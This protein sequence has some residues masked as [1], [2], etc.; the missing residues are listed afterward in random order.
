MLNYSNFIL[1][2]VEE[3][4]LESIDN[5]LFVLSGQL[6]DILNDVVDSNKDYSRIAKVFLDLD[7]TYHDKLAMSYFD[8]GSDNQSITYLNPVKVNKIRKEKGWT[9]S[10]AIK[11]LMSKNSIRIGKLAN[12]VIELHNKKF[13][14]NLV[15]TPP[16]IEDFVNA[17]KAHWDFENNKMSNLKLVSGSIISYWY[18]ENNYHSENGTLGNSCMRHD[19]CAEYLDIYTHSKNVSMLILLT[20]ENKIS[21]RAIIWEL[22]DGSLF[23][24]RV[25]TNDDSDVNLFIKWAELNNCAYKLEQNSRVGNIVKDGKTSD[26]KLEVKV[27]S[28]DYD[29]RFDEKFPYMDTLKYFYWKEGVLRNWKDL[30]KTPF[31]FL[32]DAEGSFECPTC[33]GGFIDCESCYSGVSDCERCEGVGQVKCPTCG[34]FTNL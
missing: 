14:Q 22:T 28:V 17:Y 6:C 29:S 12:K 2:G 1:E 7:V 20:P 21:G 16:E 5:G 11:N 32:E 34:G 4:I 3:L 24:D 9:I 23:M 27:Y 15:F 8:V 33:F 31:I 26:L 13:A 25:Y 10:D 30:N 18:W 19:F